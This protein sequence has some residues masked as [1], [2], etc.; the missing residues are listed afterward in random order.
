MRVILTQDV[1][2]LG[3]K[4]EMVN[5][6]DG[7]GR[8]Y[9]IPRGF[10]IP[11][12]EENVKRIEHLMKQEEKKRERLLRH[13]EEIKKLLEEN[14]ITIYKKAGKDGKLFGSVTQKDISDAIAKAL[15]VNVDKREINLEEPIRSEGMHTVEVILGK[16]VRAT[17]KI[18]VEKKE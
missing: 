6:R 17:L 14:V 9:L 7:Y 11:A 13:A 12:T 3:K 4:G 2:G 10:A 15:K 5:V 16:G 8:N 1:D 18:M